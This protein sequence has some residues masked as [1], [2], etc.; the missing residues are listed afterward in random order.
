MSHTSVRIRTG[1]LLTTDAACVCNGLNGTPADRSGGAAP[2]RR[3]AADLRK[4]VL[5]SLFRPADRLDR[6]WS[7]RRKGGRREEATS[8]TG[9][10]RLIESGAEK[11][12]TPALNRRLNVKYAQLSAL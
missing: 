2:L 10:E 8:L 11:K 1:V 7:R 3:L 6:N 9:A 5:R 4:L 12:N